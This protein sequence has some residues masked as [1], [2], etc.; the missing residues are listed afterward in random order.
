MGSAPALVDELTG[1]EEDGGASHEREDE[2]VQPEVGEARA[3]QDDAAE[4]LDVVSG[5]DDAADG[6]EERRHG[7]DEKDVAGEKDRGQD[8]AHG[9]LE[10]FSLGAGFGGDEEADSEYGEQEGQRHCEQNEDVA[11]DGHL[12]D[13]AHDDEDGAELSE[14]EDAVG[15]HLADHE[16]EGG[17]GRHGEL[18]E[19]AAL[20]FADEAEGDE[21]D[22]HDLEENG[23]EA[24]NEEVCRA[25]GRVVEDGGADLDG[26]LRGAEDA[27]EGL[28]EGDAG[29]G[30]DGLAGDGGVGAVDEDED[31]GGGAALELA[32]VV[33]G[34]LDGDAG[35]ACAH[36]GVHVGVGLHGEGEAE[37]VGCGE[38]FEELAALLGVGL[39]EDDG[40]DLA[41]VGVDCEAEEE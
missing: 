40:G 26:H 35:F 17:D 39:V 20:A 33:V 8:G 24:G 32:G 41:D 3:A 10:G 7:V 12:K 36:G 38:A 30:V 11:V 29:G 6:A 14:A 25:G 19:R 18:L 13:D 37:D 4:D 31:G 2:G 21:Q 28:L 27:G 23:D 22:G 9:E 16:A 15:N 1:G 5:G 34:D